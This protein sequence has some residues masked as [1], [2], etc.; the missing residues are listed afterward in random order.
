[1]P[2]STD[3]WHP[4]IGLFGVHRYVATNK[5][6]FEILQ[7]ESFNHPFGFLQYCNFLLL[8]QHGDTEINPP[9]RKKQL[10]YFYGIIRKSTVLWCHWKVNSLLALN[11]VLLL[12]V[13]NTIHQHDVI[14]LSETF[15]DSPVLLDDHNLPYNVTV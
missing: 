11:K 5:K 7:F 4:A 9:P 3:Q 2:V 13:Y 6:Y 12:T 8:I 14:C 10:K 1:M 15:L